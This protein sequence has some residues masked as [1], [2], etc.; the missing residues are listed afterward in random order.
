[1]SLEIKDLSFRYFKRGPL[2]LDKVSFSLNKGE[3]GVILG[4]N[5]SGKTTLFKNVLGL[6]KP[7]GGS[8]SFNGKDLSK[9]SRRERAGYI[10][11]VPQNVEFGALSVFDTVLMGRMP[12][13]GLISG[14]EDEKKT[15]KVLEEMGL[16]DLASRNVTELSGGER[17]KV[18]I[19]RAFTQEPELMVF[20]EPTGNLDIANEQLI[21]NE[22]KRIATDKGIGILTSL[23]DLNH[24]LA[25]GDK[26]F[27][28]KNGKLLYTGGK[29]IISK[30]LIKEVFD[31]EVSIIDHEGKMIIVNC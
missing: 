17:Q 28:L 23:H 13:F 16:T 26:F 11:Y 15:F 6:V 2:V 3:I 7:T 31:A 24:A 8:I 25:V 12:Y 27:F 4:K 10:A 14:K 30:E 18:A 20:D 9:V 5:G 22:A 19:A 21:L 29:D 1:M